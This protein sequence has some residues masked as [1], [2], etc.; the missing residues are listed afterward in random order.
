MGAG[1][2]ATG[3]HV[4]HIAFE[5]ESD[6]ARLVVTE[7]MPYALDKVWRAETEGLFIQQWW[8]PVGYRNVEVDIGADVG[9]VWRVV[10]ADPDGNQYSF[11]GRIIE[12]VE[13]EKLVLSLTAEIFPGTQL[14]ITQQFAGV[15]KGTIVVSTYEFP[16]EY[17]RDGYVSLGGMDRL[18]GASAKLDRLLT[19]MSV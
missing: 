16:S 13:A 19:Q 14:Q 12:R 3:G 7:R 5:L 11:Y 6:P 9:G 17:E 2:A 1:C 8:A 15:E 10:Q 4:I 18:R